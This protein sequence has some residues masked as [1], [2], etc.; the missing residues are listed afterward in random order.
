MLLIS[1]TSVILWVGELHCS[2]NVIW[3]AVHS[4]PYLSFSISLHKI[5]KTGLLD[6][7]LFVLFTVYEILKLSLYFPLEI[8]ISTRQWDIFCPLAFT[9][10]CISAP[11][12]NV[13]GPLFGCYL[14]GNWKV[15]KNFFANLKYC[16]II[17]SR[18][19]THVLPRQCYRLGAEWLEDFVE[20]MDL[21]VL[22]DA[23]L[24]MS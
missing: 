14:H 10:S 8:Q 1:A 23:R 9:T 22:I 3:T 6:S 16:L 4:Y 5:L 12:T 2:L 17:Y 15:F 21:G 11:D 24:N 13:I 18:S 19:T 20:E 7:L